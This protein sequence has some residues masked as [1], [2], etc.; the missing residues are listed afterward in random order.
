MAAAWLKRI[1][2]SDLHKQV[3]DGVKTKKRPKIAVIDTGFDP[4]ADFVDRQLQM[5]LN[6]LKKAQ[7]EYRW[8]DFWEPGVGPKDT[9]G[10]GTAMLSIIHRVAPFADICVARIAGKDEDLTKEPVRTAQNFAKVIVMRHS[11][12]AFP[13]TTKYRLLT[14]LL[15]YKKQILCQYLLAG[16]RSH[17]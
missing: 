7:D 14:G 15:E 1:T 4:Q 5:R 8:K 13:L 9:D 11:L 17:L 10:H 6:M 3:S 2:L 12:P 16:R